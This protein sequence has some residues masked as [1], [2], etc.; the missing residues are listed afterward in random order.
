MSKFR[1]IVNEGPEVVRNAVKLA[2]ARGKAR[3]NEVLSNPFGATAI[4][5][6]VQPR[7]NLELSLER[8]NYEWRKGKPKP[9]EYR[10]DLEKGY[11]FH[12]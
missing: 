3:V 4:V 5:A 8:F 11:E 12:R 9:D 7:R 2:A 6:P 1:A 10:G